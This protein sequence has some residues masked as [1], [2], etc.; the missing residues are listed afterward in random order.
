MVN[1]LNTNFTRIGYSLSDVIDNLYKASH[2][3]DSIITEDDVS[4][5]NKLI[6]GV[7]KLIAPCV[8]YLNFKDGLDFIYKKDVK[9]PKPESITRIAKAKDYRFLPHTSN[10]NVKEKVMEVLEENPELIEKL[11]VDK[12]LYEIFKKI[13]P[14][15]ETATFGE[16]LLTAEMPSIDTVIRAG[17]ALRKERL[18]YDGKK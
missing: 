3:A 8:L 1:N 17:R 14:D 6:F 12:F 16:V 15:V 4:Y 18:N 5:D 9:V 11:S 10:A 2:S 7:Y 13:N